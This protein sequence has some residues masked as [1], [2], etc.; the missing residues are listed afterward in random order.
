M[1][2]LALFVLAVD[3]SRLLCQQSLTRMKHFCFLIIAQ[4][5][6]FQ[7]IC[8]LKQMTCFLQLDMWPVQYCRNI[9]LFLKIHEVILCPPWQA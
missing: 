1:M 5:K 3:K 6:D 4:S 9:E 2:K 7:N 8:N